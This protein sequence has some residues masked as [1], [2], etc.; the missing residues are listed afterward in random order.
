MGP[1]ACVDEL[2]KRY[3]PCLYQ[4]RNHYSS[5][6]QR[7]SLVAVPSTLLIVGSCL[8]LICILARIFGKEF[9]L[10]YPDLSRRSWGIPLIIWLIL[11]QSSF[12]TD[13]LIDDAL[14]YSKFM[15]LWY[16]HK[17]WMFL[18]SWEKVWVQIFFWDLSIEPLW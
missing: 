14:S 18:S 17:C 3:F 4:E 5:E 11:F 7:R 16:N 9:T 6:V 15:G 2:D 1:N 12:L 13:G 8:L 10:V